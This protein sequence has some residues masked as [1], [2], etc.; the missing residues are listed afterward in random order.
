MT[1]DARQEKGEERMRI[2]LIGLGAIGGEIARQAAGGLLGADLELASVLVRRPRQAPGG[3]VVTTD[4]AVFLATR[5]ELVLECAG[6][7]ALREHGE[8]CLAAGADLL[9]TSAGALAD[10]GLRTRLTAAAGA[11]GRRLMVAS[12]GIGALDILAA[13]AVGGLSRV[14]VTVAKDPSA[15]HGTPAA[16]AFDLGALAAPV[17]IYR[18]P[19]REGVLLYPQNVNIAAAAAL[20]GAGLDRT[21]LVIVADPSQTR[22]LVRIDAEGVF[23]RFGFEE[24]VLPTAENPK[25]GRLV[26]MAL[27]KSLRQQVGRFLVGV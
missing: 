3:P 26:A 10:D 13:A 20:A 19:V 6:H 16:Q 17:E 8:Q 21:E 25:T 24:E 12:A 7:Q 18:G 15:W 1:D 9:A 11:A 4:R 23:G 2:G 27:V 5:P 14:R 22:H